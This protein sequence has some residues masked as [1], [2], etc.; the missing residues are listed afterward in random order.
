RKGATV[1]SSISFDGTVTSLYVPLLCG[2]K[3]HLQG[4]H[5]EIDKL[6]NEL[7]SDHCNVLYSIT[8]SY[9]HVLGQRLLGEGVQTTVG[10]FIIGG[11]PL[12]AATVQAWRQIQPGVRMIN[13]YGPTET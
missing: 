2:G 10:E 13:E 3:V 11:E 7:R 5:N 8:P 1:S 4:K 6:Y 12:S 9:L